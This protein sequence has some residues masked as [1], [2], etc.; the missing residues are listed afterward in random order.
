M[1]QKYIFIAISFYRNI[2]RQNVLC[3]KGLKGP[4]KWL[5]FANPSLPHVTFCDNQF[6]ITLRDFRTV[7]PNATRRRGSAKV[8]REIFSKFLTIFLYFG[9]LFEKIKFKKYRNQINVCLFFSNSIKA[10]VLHFFYYFFGKSKCH[11]SQWSAMYKL[12]LFLFK[13]RNVIGMKK[14]YF[15]KSRPLNMD[16]W[17]LN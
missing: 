3:E 4:F 13:R 7:S 10:L 6:V 11:V 9:L 16:K 14:I 1:A 17:L 2:V 8:S 12:K 5:F 15:C